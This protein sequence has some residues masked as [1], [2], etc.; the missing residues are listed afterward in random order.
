[1]T[2]RFGRTSCATPAKKPAATSGTRA[3]RARTKASAPFGF[4]VWGRNGARRSGGSDSGRMK[5]PYAKFAKLS[6]AAAQNGVRRSIV[7]RAP[8]AAGPR[9]KP[10]PNATPSVPKRAA[11]RSGGVTSATYAPA[12]AT[13]PNASMSRST[14]TKMNANAARLTPSHY[15]RMARRVAVDEIAAH[16]ERMWDRLARAGIPYTRPQGSPPRDRAGKRRFLDEI[17]RGRFGDASFDGKRVLALAGGGGWDAILFAELGAYTTLFD[18][19]SRQL[20]T[21][22]ALARLRGTEINHGRRGT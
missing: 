8:P 13:M 17:T 18:I 12:G 21:V 22:R 5:A 9:M 1:M 19:S 14:V 6:T 11:R 16:N 3:G 15:R 10:I 20:A 2:N 4:A 7:P